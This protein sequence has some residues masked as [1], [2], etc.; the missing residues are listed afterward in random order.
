MGP[1]PEI[2]MPVSAVMSLHAEPKRVAG[3]T[4]AIEDNLARKNRV[5]MRRPRETDPAFVAQRYAKRGTVVQI[6]GDGVPVDLQGAAAGILVDCIAAMS[7]MKWT[8]PAPAELQILCRKS[9]NEALRLSFPR[10]PCGPNLNRHSAWVPGATATPGIHQ[11][12]AEPPGTAPICESQTNKPY[13]V[14][15][16]DRKSGEN[17]IQGL[18]GTGTDCIAAGRDAGT[19]VRAGGLKQPSADSSLRPE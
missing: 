10:K 8:L 12:I 11:Q 17:F 7:K 18:H 6:P 13:F 19:G 5:G 4:S 2:A 1:G 9:L 3:Q 15:A 14:A 16:A